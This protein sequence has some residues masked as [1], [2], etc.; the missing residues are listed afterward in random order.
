VIDD[1]APGAGI[2]TERDILHS[3]GVGQSIDDELVRRHLTSDVVYAAADWSL[4]RA[5][6]AMVRG[7]QARRTS[8]LRLARGRRPRE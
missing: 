1:D 8:P 4:E 2:I 7:A 5:A 6:S 3:N